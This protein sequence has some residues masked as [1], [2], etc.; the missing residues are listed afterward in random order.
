MS[1]AGTR[2]SARARGRTRGPAVVRLLA[3]ALL[4]ALASSG[5]GAAAAGGAARTVSLSNARV[6]R[7]AYPV[8]EAIV[9]ATPS[10]RARAVG[11]LRLLT[12]DLQAELYVARTSRTLASGQTWISV[13]VPGRPNGDTGWVPSGALGPLHVVSDR[14]RIDRVRLRA[15]L[16]RGGRPIF[17]A[18]VGVGKPGT[19][20]PAGSFYVMEK[21]ITVRAPVYGPYAIGTS[22]YAPTLSE[23]PGG[24]VVGIHGT[25]EPRL[26]P[27]RPSHGCI[28]MRNGD[29]S[30]LWHL[31]VV[32]TPVE[33][34]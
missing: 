25:D 29:V 19:I 10:S 13:D 18:P 15:T 27:G 26:I 28:R 34:T 31:I 4:A 5:A 16:Y 9:R 1:S 20:T 21:L 14:L 8:D 24:G 33:I 12:T 11:R 6:T 2:R 22:A 17:S 32:G 23:W 7:W 3:A 30:R